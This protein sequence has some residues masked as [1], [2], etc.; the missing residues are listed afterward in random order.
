MTPLL[1]DRG[2]MLFSERNVDVRGAGWEP[3]AAYDL[4]L[5]R[6]L[7]HL[8][9]GV[10]EVT[11][12][13][14]LEFKDRASGAV[15]EPE[16]TRLTRSPSAARYNDNPTWTE[17]EKREFAAELEETISKTW[18][19]K[20]RIT[21]GPCIP[22]MKMIPALTDIGVLFEIKC[23][24][25][26]SAFE[27]SHWNVTIAKVDEPKRNKVDDDGGTFSNGTA[28]FTALC[29]AKKPPKDGATQRP[30]VHEFGHML[31]YSDEYV[32]KEKK[33]EPEDTKAYAYA[34]DFP[35]VMNRGEAIQARHYVLFTEWLNTQFR[36]QSTT[37]KDD[38]RW[39]VNGRLNAVR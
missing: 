8:Q 18:S 30:I 10:L 14:N 4:A 15:H 5:F 16:K 38:I 12:I 34:W 6:E 24:I 11:L 9:R 33:E 27:H 22:D 26:M 21:T 23:G 1:P 35:S 37:G 31:G 3:D 29:L 25:E 19:E 39:L 32:E 2:Q 13:M 20:H 28:R 36:F 17:A 7:G